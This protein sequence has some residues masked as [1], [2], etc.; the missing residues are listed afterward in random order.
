MPL[1]IDRGVNPFGAG[2][3]VSTGGCFGGCLGGCLGGS[4]ALFLLMRKKMQQ[5]PTTQTA[6]MIPM[7]IVSDSSS[8]SPLLGDDVDADGPRKA[9]E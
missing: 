5:R 9:A 7:S 8:S 2:G 6:M 1:P 4:S 3:L